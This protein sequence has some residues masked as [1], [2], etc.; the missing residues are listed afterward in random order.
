[1]TLEGKSTSAEYD[2]SG[3]IVGNLVSL[4]TLR[5]SSTALK[6]R[7]HNHFDQRDREHKYYISRPVRELHLMRVRRSKTNEC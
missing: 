6:Q 3:A 7:D 4:A 5:A 1:M 2:F